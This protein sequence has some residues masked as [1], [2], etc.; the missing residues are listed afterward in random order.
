[1]YIYMCWCIYR[2]YIQIYSDVFIYIYIYIIRSHGPFG[3][4]LLGML[5]VALLLSDDMDER[6]AEGL[7]SV[8]V[9][10]SRI[11]D[12]CRFATRRNLI[13]ATMASLR[14][15]GDRSLSVAKITKHAKPLPD[16][17]IEVGSLRTLLVALG[18]P[19][20]SAL[21]VDVVAS[22]LVRT[23][24]PPTTPKRKQQAAG[25]KPAL[26]QRK[27]ARKFKALGKKHEQAMKTIT[28][29]QTENR[30]LKQESSV[31]V[32]SGARRS[33]AKVSGRVS[34]W[35]GY[36]ISMMR[37][38]THVG[39]CG[40]IRMLEL[41]VRRQTVERWEK[42]FAVNI[43]T[44][45]RRYFRES[46]AEVMPHDGSWSIINI[47]GGAAN[48]A[49]AAHGCKA[50]NTAFEVLQRVSSGVA[51]LKKAHGPIQQQ[52]VHCYGQDVRNMLEQ[53]TDALGIPSWLEPCSPG[54]MRSYNF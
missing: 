45:S 26:P 24:D 43:L 37:N 25:R 47:R 52:P 10:Y 9:R 17:D 11:S 3:S 19:I 5:L 2:Y 6:L 18:K 51:M 38:M 41:L 40:L 34:L 7:A 39:T 54:H 16:A 27:L 53:S 21:E 1:M 15:V 32:A 14:L 22:R 50:F 44:Q 49:V 48:S 31:L 20:F 8:L 29:L 30:I 13:D 46:E 28:D 4:D 35:F 33:A 42:V 12:R 23:A 36:K